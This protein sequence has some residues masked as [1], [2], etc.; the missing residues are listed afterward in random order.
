MGLSLVRWRS[1]SRHRGR[2][3]VHPQVGIGTERDQSPNH[4][5]SV[6]NARIVQW[7]MTDLRNDPI[8]VR[9]TLD[10]RDYCGN[11]P[12]ASGL[13]ELNVVHVCTSG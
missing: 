2:M 10:E 13:E 12:S 1:G 9:A 6:G 11:V 5:W 4:L 8:W 7:G 3:I